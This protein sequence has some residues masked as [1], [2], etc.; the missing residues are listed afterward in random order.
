MGLG[1]YQGMDRATIVA[2]RAS[3][4]LLFIKISSQ[5][6]ESIYC[7]PL[8]TQTLSIHEGDIFALQ[9]GGHFAF[10]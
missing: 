10:G 2:F 8:N 5:M 6:P 4:Q 9:L 7:R 3:W 1:E